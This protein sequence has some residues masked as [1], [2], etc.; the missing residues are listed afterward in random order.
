MS[1]DGISNYIDM[2]SVHVSS[3]FSQRF[4]Y[5]L[6]F[7]REQEIRKGVAGPNQ[8]RV[9]GV[10]FIWSQDDHLLYIGKGHK[11]SV[12]DEIW[13]KLRTPDKSGEKEEGWRFPDNVFANDDVDGVEDITEGRAKLSAYLID[14]E[15]FSSL[16][17]VYWPAP[18]F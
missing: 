7:D 14:P 10:Y 8:Y 16:V 13:G 6:L 12:R 18:I 17:E 3:E 5:Q 15:Y 11:T 1:P 2:L 9:S 4:D